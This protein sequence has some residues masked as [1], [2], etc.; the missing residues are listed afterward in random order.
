MAGSSPGADDLIAELARL[1]QQDSKASAP[2]PTRSSFALRIPGNPAP[3]ETQP[4]PADTNEEPVVAEQPAPVPVEAH[5]PTTKPIAAAQ[6]PDAFKFDFDLNLPKAPVA[7][8]AIT[9][10]IPAR[11]ASPPLAETTAAPPAE[12][13]SIADLIAAELSTEP[14]PAV[15]APIQPSV[16]GSE[17]PAVAAS[18]SVPVEQDSAPKAPPSKPRV[19]DAPVPRSAEPPAP[20]PSEK[21]RFKVPPVFGMTSKPVPSPASAGL[22]SS[23]RPE[24]RP[25]PIL[26]AVTR[27]V[28]PVPPRV[29]TPSAVSR[30]VVPVDDNVGSDPIDEIE[31]L[32]GK[33]MRVEFDTPPE[34]EVEAVPAPSRRAPSPALRSLATPTIPT[35]PVAAAAAP[36]STA[37]EAIMAAARA[38]GADVGWVEQPQV[39][40]PKRAKKIKEPRVR[41]EREP[42]AGG[43][44]RALAGPLIALTLLLAAGIGLYWVLGMGNNS[45]PPPLLT[46]DATPVKEVPA[47]EPVADE[48][49]QS[50]VFNEID[51]VVPGAEEQLVSRDQADVNEVTQTAPTPD[52]SEDGLANRRVRTVTVRPDGTIVSG[53]DSVAGSTILPVDRPVVPD[54]PGAQ[55]ASPELLAS[56]QASTATTSAGATFSNADTAAGSE[57]PAAAGATDPVTSPQDD[58]AATGAEPADPAT[59]A[60]TVDA[61]G[62]QPATSPEAATAPEPPVP[63]VTP[64]IPGSTVEAVD[65]EGNPIAGQTAP[66][67]LLRPSSLA[68]QAAATTPAAVQTA[69]AGGNSLPA[70]P[71]TSLL[72]ALGSSAA[73]TQPAAAAATEPAPT[74]TSTPEAA[75]PAA[76][77]ASTAPAYVQLASQTTEADARATAEAMV[78]RYGPLFGGANLEVQRVDLGTR[79]IFYRVRV[80]ASSRDNADNIC[81]NVKAA[82]GDCFTM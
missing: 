82:G 40:K 43:F 68:P 35:A 1:M 62:Q 63:P 77:P 28:A 73:T 16:R 17:P 10:S 39:E 8:P 81:V 37:D 74:A 49:Q 38:T 25:E 45:G 29:A 12:H 23:G 53:E 15:A 69:S 30:P 78:T 11:P 55:T 19:A 46:A 65:T 50:V 71:A 36:F 72:P 66:V 33:A 76:T 34:A 61:S 60:D 48:P 3:T 31:S 80:P 64:V 58:A 22:P 57:T 27:E 13:D 21:D 42:R 26:A 44:G 5:T 59:G 4:A 54:V 18:V 41:R 2:A 56:T 79:G 52:N 70:A 7:D 47:V 9:S 20:P 6:A 24:P 14:A 51:G 32:I 75:I 67:P